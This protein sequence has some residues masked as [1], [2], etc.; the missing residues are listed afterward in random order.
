MLLTP[1][2][3]LF[4]TLVLTCSAVASN[5][6]AAADPSKIIEPAR[7]DQDDAKVET[8]LSADVLVNA[9]G[10]YKF[11]V[12][13]SADSSA[14]GLRI[15]RDLQLPLGRP[16]ILNGMTSREVIDRVK[17]TELTIGPTTIRNLQLPA[18]RERDLGG[19][20]LLGIDALARQRLMMDFET[21]LVTVEDARKPVI[22]TPGEVV[23]AAKRQRGQLVLTEVRAAGFPLEAV[24][25]TGSEITVG[26]L[27]LRDRLRGDHTR[28]ETV[29]VVGVTGET[30]KMQLARI[31]ELQLGPVLLRDVPVAFADAPPFAKWGLSDRPAL[32]MGTDLMSRFGWVSLDFREAKIRF[33]PR[34]CA[35]QKI[36]E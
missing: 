18:L 19:D 26:N 34:R 28:I 7:C 29:D 6:L 15:A 14:V 12:D 16:V 35:A 5:V 27:A 11:I 36:S 30:V 3:R 1:R 2:R 13:S 24:I 22:P 9:R 20:G 33:Q 21:H 32:L 17:V 25:H 23:I 10:P 4:L 8:R 31:D